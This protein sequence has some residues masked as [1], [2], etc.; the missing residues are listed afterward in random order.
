[1]RRQLLE[2]L[3]HLHQ[4]GL[5]HNDVKHDNMVIAREADAYELK[6]MDLGACATMSVNNLIPKDK[7]AKGYNRKA[8]EVTTAQRLVDGRKA[9]LYGAG[10]V[11]LKWM[12][13]SNASTEVKA[14]IALLTDT[15]PDKRPLAA[16]ILD[17]KF[18]P[19]N[20]SVAHNWLF[21]AS[22]R[23]VHPV[24]ATNS[25]L[26]DEL[27]SRV[28]SIDLLHD[29]YTRTFPVVFS[30]AQSVSGPGGRKQA[31]FDSLV[32]A[33]TRLTQPGGVMVVTDLQ[34]VKSPPDSP[35]SP[36][37]THEFSLDGGEKIATRI[38]IEMKQVYTGETLRQTLRN[39]GPSSR[40]QTGPQG[41]P[42]DFSIPDGTF[43]P[44][45]KV[46]LS[47]Q[48]VDVVEKAECVIKAAAKAA[49]Q[50]PDSAWS[51]VHKRIVIE[52][53]RSYLSGADG[54][55]YEAWV[56]V[57]IA[58]LA[59]FDPPDDALLVH[60]ETLIIKAFALLK[61]L[62]LI[63]C[64][65]YVFRQDQSGELSNNLVPVFVGKLGELLAA[66][67]KL[68]RLETPI[69]CALTADYG[70]VNGV[71]V[72][73]GTMQLS[74]DM[75]Q[76]MALIYQKALYSGPEHFNNLETLRLKLAA[77]SSMQSHLYEWEKRIR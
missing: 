39:L 33:L 36:R 18:K 29:R 67:S 53:K 37:I 74:V 61:W 4:H 52:V 65:A 71:A 16:D 3:N 44:G 46:D 30:M 69:H 2:G 5:C 32:G 60:R 12:V 57:V 55:A 11:I 34:A 25:E 62:R 58:A 47:G 54:Q 64:S 15:D 75:L 70:T 27:E 7:V 31:V 28:H 63:V 40:L 42:C 56:R 38:G 24:T 43:E 26:I 6:L 41:S 72:D 13:G 45:Q 35:D 1:V 14:L 59:E 49:G 8:P 17:P 21:D 73:N 50:D 51:L 10:E 19:A 9:D 48:M 76:Q 22:S 66:S 23:D 77:S 68:S 20:G